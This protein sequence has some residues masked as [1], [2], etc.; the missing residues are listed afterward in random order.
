MEERGKDEEE[1][2]YTEK[3]WDKEIQ[4]SNKR[5]RKQRDIE[6]KT[7]IQ[8]SNER[9]RKSQRDITTTYICRGKERVTEKQ[10]EIK[11]RGQRLQNDEIKRYKE[12]T[13][14]WW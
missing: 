5:Y 12:V 1:E 3:W 6:E 2:R 9:K 4:R 10:F 7:K 13:G 11:R 8:R 14:E